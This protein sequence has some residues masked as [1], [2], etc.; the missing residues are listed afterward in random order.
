M[1]QLVEAQAQAASG[2]VALHEF[3]MSSFRLLGA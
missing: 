2:A 3:M 1:L